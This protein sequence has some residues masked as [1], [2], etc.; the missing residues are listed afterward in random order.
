MAKLSAARAAALERKKK[1]QKAAEEAADRLKKR[2]EAK[3][4]IE[5]IN[6]AAAAQRN[7][8][9]TDRAR[10]E[11]LQALKTEGVKDDEASLN[12]LIELE[13][14][15]EAEIQRQAKESIIASNAVKNQRLADLDEELEKLKAL[16]N[17]RRA[18]IAGGTITSTPAA[19][20]SVQRGL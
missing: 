1:A 11:A 4:D 2:L 10:V 20:V 12:K 6:L 18:S 5:N 8:S 9:E 3:F 7:L 17:A 16:A 13:K 15:R 19:D 14:K